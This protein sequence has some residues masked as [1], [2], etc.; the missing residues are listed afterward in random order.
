MISL[1]TVVCTHQRP[2]ALT[3]F[4]HS[5]RECNQPG[6]LRNQLVIIWN[7]AVDQEYEKIKA[8]LPKFSVNSVLIAEPRKG[9]SNARNKALA[10]VE[11]DYIF[12]VDD[13][14]VLHQDVFHQILKRVKND[15]PD[16]LGSRVL[17]FDETDNLFTTRTEIEPARLTKKS[18][19]FGFIHGCSMLVSRPVLNTVS[20]FDTALG[21]GSYL[22]SGEDLDFLLRGF[23]HGMSVEYD[24][25]IIVYHNHGRKDGDTVVQL[26]DGYSMGAGGVAIK[27]LL[28]GKPGPLIWKFRT[29]Y[30]E[31]VK[32]IRF[33][34]WDD[35]YLWAIRPAVFTVCGMACYPVVSL[36]TWCKK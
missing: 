22:R 8:L 3:R 35:L 18:N 29:I 20:N 5:F 33:R 24:P 34:A 26:F 17:L 11:S 32:A 10:N 28:L 14:V 25:D 2:E 21:A 13:D 6:D 36:T 19:P 16:I 1:S 4:L 27:H 9:L 30:S 12:F 15:P 31:L 7:D 23:S